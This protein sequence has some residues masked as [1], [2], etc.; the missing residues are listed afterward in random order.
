M[1]KYPIIS[2]VYAAAMLFL[3]GVAYALAPPGTSAG[4]ALVIPGIAA[5]AILVA[6]ALGFI[7]DIIWYFAKLPPMRIGVWPA[8]ALSALLAVAFAARAIPATAAYLDARGAL[9]DSP[10][11]ERATAATVDVVEGGPRAEAL[12]KDYL[13]MALWGLT[14]VS[15]VSLVSLLLLGPPRGARRA[16]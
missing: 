8:I 11:A 1:L 3:G 15:A 5:G 12:R 16:D 13:I 4:T 6:T 2:I 14:A 7:V 10:A 9:V